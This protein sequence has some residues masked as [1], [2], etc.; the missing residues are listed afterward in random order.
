CCHSIF[1]VLSLIWRGSYGKQ[2]VFYFLS[3]MLVTLL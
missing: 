2:I 1:G 3:Y